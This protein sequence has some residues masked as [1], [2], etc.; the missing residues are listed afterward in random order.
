MLLVA[1]AVIA[2]PEFDSQ[3]VYLRE[4]LLVDFSRLHQNCFK[5]AVASS[6]CGLGLAKL[7]R[8]DVT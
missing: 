2:S 8:N 1:C 3:H 6:T 4:E 5:A 7:I